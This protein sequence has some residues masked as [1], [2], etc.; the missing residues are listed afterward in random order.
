LPSRLLWSHQQ[1]T[2]PPSHW[3]TPLL[4]L[5]LLLLLRAL[6]LQQMRLQ[7]WLGCLAPAACRCLH[8]SLQERQQAVEA[9]AAHVTPGTTNCYVRRHI[10][11]RQRH[12][13]VILSNCT[14]TYGGVRQI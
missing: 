7:V 1:Q 8:S 11:A 4:L 14:S 6:R 12:N 2:L 10:R 3:L 9:T 5:L 13:L